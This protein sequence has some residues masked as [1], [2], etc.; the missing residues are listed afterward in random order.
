MRV[1]KPPVLLAALLLSVIVA[2]APGCRPAPT[3]GDQPPVTH[4]GI[5]PQWGSQAPGEAAVQMIDSS[6]GWAVTRDGIARTSDGGSHWSAV[7]PVGTAGA[8]ESGSAWPDA[9][10]GQAHFFGPDAA[11]VARAE[12]GNTIAVYRTADGGV[13]WTKSSFQTLSVDAPWLRGIG[14]ADETNGWLLV[15]F[16]GVAMGSELVGIYTTTDGGAS[17]TPA[18][19]I[20][21]A[22]Q[23]PDRL[24]LG[25]TKSGVTFISDK[26]GWVAGGSHADGVWLYITHDGGR[27]WRQAG[28]PVPRGYSTE[29]GAVRTYPPLF[30]DRAG[31]LPAAF[32]AERSLIFFTS[33]DGGATWKATMAVPAGPDATGFVWAFA[34]AA[35]GWLSDGTNLYATT[36][37]AVNWTA[38]AADKRLT[39]LVRSGFRI[40]ELNFIDSATGWALLRSGD[41]ATGTLALLR[42][43]DGGRNWSDC[44]APTAP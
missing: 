28:L 2:V 43:T 13:N 31:L 38:V 21:P 10:F 5:R 22:S 3:G 37:G 11:V 18:T 19:V 44:G 29:G 32:G 16:G 4:A 41:A 35:H 15:N 12:A 23:Q 30:F 14:F 24:P 20:D 27:T 26:V 9:A 36:D 1:R 8:S 34:D 42:T 7:T 40:T 25:G 17:W 39:D 33:A 6:V